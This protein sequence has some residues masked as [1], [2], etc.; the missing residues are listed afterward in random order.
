MTTKIES[1]GYSPLGDDN[2]GAATVKKKKPQSVEVVKRRT[3]YNKG[4]KVESEEAV[5]KVERARHILN[6]YGIKNI[7]NER[8]TDLQQSKILIYQSL[9]FLEIHQKCLG[10]IMKTVQN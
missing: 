5:K 8:I 4:V 6:T 9:Y 3:D 2:G 1:F 7:D 10:L